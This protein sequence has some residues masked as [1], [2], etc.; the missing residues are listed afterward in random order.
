MGEVTN[1]NVSRGRL[2]IRGAVEVLTG[3]HIGTGSAMGIGLVDS[4]TVRDPITNRPMIPGSSLKGRLRHALVDLV[5]GKKDEVDRL[6]GSSAGEDKGG[7]TRLF[8]RDCALKD[9]SAEALK[10]ATGSSLK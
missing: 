1:E 10:S 2:I 4:C 3:L 6:F 7:L 9:D 8:V 5:D